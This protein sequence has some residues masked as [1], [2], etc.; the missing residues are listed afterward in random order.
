MIEKKAK[1]R[2]YLMKCD[3]RDFYDMDRE[4]SDEWKE[5]KFGQLLRNR[6]EKGMDVDEE[7]KHLR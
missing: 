1:Q 5:V 3:E 6:M 7:Y 2:A 4:T